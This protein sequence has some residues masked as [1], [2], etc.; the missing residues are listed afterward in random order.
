M[1]V[2]WT[3]MVHYLITVLSLVRHETW[4][5]S[6]VLLW[7]IQGLRS[8][9]FPCFAI[10]TDKQ[11]SV[12]PSFSL[13]HV[14]VTLSHHFACDVVWSNDVCYP[15]AFCWVHRWFVIP[16]VLTVPGFKKSKVAAMVRPASSNGDCRKCGGT[17]GETRDPLDKTGKTFLQ[18][19]CP[20]AQIC[21]VCYGFIRNN[22]TYGEHRDH[23]LNEK[24]NDPVYKTEFLKAR[25]EW[26]EERQGGGKRRRLQGEKGAGDLKNNS[27]LWN[28]NG[29]K[30]RAGSYCRNLINASCCS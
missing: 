11:M 13:G 25:S 15:E 7:H 21:R 3:D 28:I 9:V 26:C 18:R 1:K 4:H 22:P 20:S 6:W 5:E 8:Q 2:K 17:F 24:L 27:V 29:F 19:R 10:Y 14:F 16:K 12:K 30:V 23:E